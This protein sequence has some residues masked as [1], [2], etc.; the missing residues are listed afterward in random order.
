MYLLSNYKVIEMLKGVVIV[1]M[2]ME[3]RKGP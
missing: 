3:I 1:L 2:G